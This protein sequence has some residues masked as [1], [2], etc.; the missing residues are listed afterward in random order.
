M[1]HEGACVGSD[2]DIFFLD[3]HIEK[4]KVICADCHRRSLCQGYGL[5][6]NLP[7][8]VWG[9]LSRQDRVELLGSTIDIRHITE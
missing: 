7:F 2:P 5:L 8:G 4:A 1:E 3:K 6:H 9:G